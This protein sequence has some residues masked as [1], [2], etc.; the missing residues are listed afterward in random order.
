MAYFDSI[1]F[2]F[3]GVLADTEPVH[4][5]CWAEVL[6][7]AGVVLGWDFYHDYCIGIDDREMLRMMATQSDPPRDWE[8]LWKLYP[9]KRELFQAR[10]SAAPPF[11]PGLQAFLCGLSGRYK[12]A[13]VSS[14][15]GSEVE[16]LLVTGGLRGYFQTLVGAENVKRHKPAPDPYLLAAER[17][18]SR[19][20]LVV[21]DSEA[22]FAS[23]RAAG[24]EVL[25]VKNP[26]DLPELVEQRLAV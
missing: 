23:G 24:F 21:E 26:A 1:L 22:G 10:M 13:V 25:A 18:G 20:P 14:S 19:T 6:A 2:D 12:L 11:H 7:P 15:A 9:A 8:E 4:C 3:D 17:L 16:P 5:A